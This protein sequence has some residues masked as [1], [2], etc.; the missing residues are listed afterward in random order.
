MSVRFDLGDEA[1][2]YVVDEHDGFRLVAPRRFVGGK[3]CGVF[4]H[5]LKHA[6]ITTADGMNLTIE[7]VMATRPPTFT[8]HPNTYGGRAAG[9]L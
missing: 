6:V 8:V 3:V 1:C 4:P 5:S 9:E 2:G 7:I